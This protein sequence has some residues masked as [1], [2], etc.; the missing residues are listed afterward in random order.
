MA[1]S[2]QNSKGT[3][4][5]LHSRP[6]RGNTGSKLYFFAR[7]EKEGVEP[8]LPKGYEV[9]ETSTGLPVLKKLQTT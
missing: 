5:Y 4:Y 2:H 7:E 8:E 6:A 1:F 9:K 3:T